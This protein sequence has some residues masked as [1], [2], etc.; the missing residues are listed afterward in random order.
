[1]GP[2]HLNEI[3]CTGFEKSVT[4]CKFNTE[5]QGCNHEEDAAVRCNVPAMGFQNQLRLSGGRN[6]YEGR[7]EVLAERN[8]TLKWGTVCSENW[9][10]VEAM[11][12]CRQLGL[13]FASHAF[14]HAAS[15]HELEMP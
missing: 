8:G 12:V 9:S 15:K 1:M 2:I 3:D 5:S 7:V 14:Q 6:P 10:T 4:D 11:V 13:G